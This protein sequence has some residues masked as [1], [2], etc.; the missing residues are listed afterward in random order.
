MKSYPALAADLET[1]LET[2]SSAMPKLME[3]FSGVIDKATADGQLDTKTKELI[4]LSIAAVV[5]CDPCIAHHVK[6]VKKAKATRAEVAEALGVA[7]LM[8]GGPA[9]AYSVSALE[10][11]DQ[12]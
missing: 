11:Y 12:F 6:A 10:A 9:L 7:I 4:A 1:G 3:A 8:G 2:Y 5:R